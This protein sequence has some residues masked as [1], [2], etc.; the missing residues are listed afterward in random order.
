MTDRRALKLLLV[1]V[2]LALVGFSAPSASTATLTSSSRNDV[3]RVSAAADWTPPTVAMTSPGAPVRGS[4]ALKATASDGET[5][6]QDVTIEYLPADGAGWATVCTTRVAPYTCTWSTT[7]LADGTYALRARATDKAGYTATS[8]PVDAVVANTVLVVLTDPGDAVKGTVAL[9]ASVH[10]AGPLSYTLRFEYAPAGTTTWK[11]VCTA[12]AANPT[13]SWSTIT[14]ANGDY[15]LRAV[16]VAGSTTYTSATV[17]DVTVDNLAPTVT[18][19][20]PGTPLSG[21]RT[22]SATAADAHSDV[23]SVTLQYA[24]TGT[25]TWHAL[26]TVTEAPFSCRVDTTTIPDGSY[27][28]RAL[29]TDAAGNTA[30][31]TAVTKR[32]VDNTIS[33][34]SVEDPGAFLTGTVTIAASASSTAGVASVRI[35]YAPS[36]TTT[37]TDICTDTTAPWSCS[38]DTTKVAEGSYDLRAVLTARNGTVSTSAVDPDH[39]VDNTPLR[40]A[41]VQTANGGLFAGRL[42]NGDSITFTYTDQINPA[43]VTAG[44]NG[45]PKAVS[46]RVRD[47]NLLG[48][49]SKGDTLDVLAGS[50]PVNLGSVNLNQDYV[51][52]KKTLVFN[53]T[54]TAT[55]TTV[56]GVVRTVVT[57]RLGSVA[58]GS[59]V[60]LVLAGSTM[61]WTPSASATDLGGSPCSTSRVN[62]TGPLDREF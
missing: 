8:D 9:S 26:C 16:A 50:V 61:A 18:V 44:W 4:V 46:L 33:S 52:S 21:L 6:V 29:A 20:D 56:D 32:V 27:S 7:A 5:G 43:T 19:A 53:A 39:R 42:E 41:D 37:W 1:S 34:V 51:K 57:V 15:D 35:Q 11:T 25:S 3:S 24:L 12:T 48:L 13:C 54:M 23:A 14:H 30:T 28:V 2:L 17:P 22:F 36:G 62:E 59:G 45:A 10:N 38:W 58:S 55:T 60:R 47:G 31:S 40:G 49:G